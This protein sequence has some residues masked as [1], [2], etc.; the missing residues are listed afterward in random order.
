MQAL[1]FSEARKFK[2]IKQNLKMA[3]KLAT[4]NVLLF[5]LCCLGAW[6][7]KSA[8]SSRQNK[9]SEALPCEI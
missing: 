3:T 8:T 7:H 1:Q 5:F 2:V 4:R 9:V 6:S